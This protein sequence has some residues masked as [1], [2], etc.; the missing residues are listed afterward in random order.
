MKHEFNHGTIYRGDCLDLM[1]DVPDDS[2][3]LILADLPYGT[4]ACHWDSIIP[5][6][7]LWE[8]YK[9]I[10]KEA[11]VFA[12][13]ACQPF[14]SVLVMSNIDWFRNDYCWNKVSGANFMNLKNRPWKTKEDVLIFSKVPGFTYNPIRINRIIRNKSELKRTKVTSTKKA[15]HKHYGMISKAG[16]ITGYD[17]DNKKHPVSVIKFSVREKGYLLNQNNGTRKPVKLFEYLIK[18]YTNK[19]DTVLDNVIGSGTTGV[20]CYNT[21]RRFIGMEKDDEIYSM[22]VKRID[23]ETRQ[24]KLFN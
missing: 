18:T 15:Y 23:N 9:R 5:F 24:I 3:D 4:T 19:G 10:A 20:A 2:V 1:R 7:P 6:K 17:E 12:F 8:A 22:A 16:S 21:G 13:T 11:C 14:T